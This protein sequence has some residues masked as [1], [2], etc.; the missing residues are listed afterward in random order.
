MES[1]RKVSVLVP[2]HNET[3]N[4][5]RL[6]DALHGLMDSERGY[7]WEVLLVDDGSTDGT[8]IGMK[9]LRGRD[10]RFA[11]ISLSRNFGKE[12]AMLAGFDHVG[13]D[14]LVIM[15]A[16]LQDPVEVIPGMLRLWEQGYDDV[17][18]KRVDRGK[19]SFLRR[20]LSMAY[21]RLLQRIANVDILPNVGD[22]RLLDRKCVDAL[23]RLRE[24]QR[25]TK[26][27]YN[28]IGF[29][30]KEVTFE[31]HDRT[32]GHSSFTYR[33][34]FGLAINGITS[35]STMPL[36]ISSIMGIVVS[37]IA[38][39]YMIYIFAKTIIVGE[40][41]RGFP[42]LVILILFLG[43]VQLISLGIIGEYLGQIFH[44]EK[45]RPVYLIDDMDGVG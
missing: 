16:D 28:W 3:D 29:R 18:A 9:T 20:R 7:E 26:G 23:C 15:D 14:C 27:L 17:Y 25:Y 42:T 45:R 40:P 13:G 36:Q 21:Y 35:Y 19:E 37:L 43:G 5:E 41:V 33:K 32:V 31:R 6:Y 24:T 11:W 22:F 2:C 38:F 4:L 34:L 30:K 44:E 1:K 8:L 10:S 12:A 39:V